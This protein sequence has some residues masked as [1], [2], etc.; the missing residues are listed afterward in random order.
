MKLKASL[1][2]AVL[3]LSQS[4]ANAN[5][6]VVIV[7]RSGGGGIVLAGSISTSTADDRSPLEY[8][9]WGLIVFGLF[10]NHDEVIHI[11]NGAEITNLA[12]QDVWDAMLRESRVYANHPNLIKSDTALAN[13]ANAMGVQA[14]DLAQMVLDLDAKVSSNDLQARYFPK[15]LTQ[16]HQIQAFNNLVALSQL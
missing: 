1:L 4:L 8:V 9:G 13:A 7:K 12:S 11:A 16:A 15:G 6:R 14:K 2:V 3:L 5:D 10:A